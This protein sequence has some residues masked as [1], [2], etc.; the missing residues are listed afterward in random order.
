MSA[1]GGKADIGRTLQCLLLTQSRHSVPR[2]VATQ[3]DAFCWSQIPAVIAL[4]QASGRVVLSLGQAMARRSRESS[5]R[6][7]A[8]PRKAETLKR[9]A[10]SALRRRYAAAVPLLS[11]RKVSFAAS[12]M[13]R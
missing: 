12:V 5:K 4:L 13:R 8:R 2:I 1:F 6:A 11:V 3:N 10:A 7:K 9:R